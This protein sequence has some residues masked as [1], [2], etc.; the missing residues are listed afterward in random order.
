MVKE[1]TVAELKESRGEEEPGGNRLMCG[2]REYA[3]G[4]VPGVVN[5]PLEQIEARLDD[6]PLVDNRATR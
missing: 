6:V 1:I 4:H 5:I 3:A 2:Q